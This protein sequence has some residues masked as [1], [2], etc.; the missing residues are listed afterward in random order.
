ML[1][2]NPV[3][4]GRF[5]WYLQTKN[6]SVQNVLEELARLK[7]EQHQLHAQ[8]QNQFVYESQGVTDH[9]PWAPD[10]W[11]CKGCVD[12]LVIATCYQWWEEERARVKATLPGTLI[13]HLGEEDGQLIVF[14]WAR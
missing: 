14:L 13:I 10:Q 9:Q 3:E 2:R 7:H 4:A 11:F 5:Q 6:Q 12:M 8:T 1:R